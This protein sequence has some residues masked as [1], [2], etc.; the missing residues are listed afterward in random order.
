MVQTKGQQQTFQRT[1]DE[2]SQHRRSLGRVG[3]PDAKVVDTGLHH[4]PE[5]GEHQRDDHGIGDDHHGHEPLAVE[6]GQ[7]VRQL[8]EV[9][10]FIVSYA[11]HKTGDDAHEYAH[12]Q[13]RCA[14]DGGKI[15]VDGD[16][17][18]KQG[19]GHGI[20]ILQHSTGDAED[21]AGDDVDERKGQ[22]SR[23]G[24]ACAFFCPAAADG[25]RE[26]DVQVVDDGPADVL[27]RSADGHD[28]G[29]IATAH[30][31][32]LAQTD[33]QTR[34]RHDGDDGHQNLAQFLQKVEIDEPF[35]LGSCLCGCHDVPPCSFAFD[36]A[37]IALR[38]H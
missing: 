4:R 34:R 20:G 27:H 19:V 23:K 26:Q 11:A 36:C 29:N 28:G 5:Q 37:S 6:E 25:D 14:Q 18:P 24:T 3:D 10:V 16:L 15:A 31:H 1:I 8:A 9:I 21:V 7:C 32:Q 35:L 2:R 38:L 22:H 33:H 30:L 13:G 12:I 17:L